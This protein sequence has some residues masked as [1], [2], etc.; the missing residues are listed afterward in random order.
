MD[1]L[2]LALDARPVGARK[3]LKRINSNDRKIS[4]LIGRLAK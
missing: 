2:R 3:I 4:K 1:I